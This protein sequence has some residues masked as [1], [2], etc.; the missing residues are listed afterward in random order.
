M[1][2]DRTADGRVNLQVDTTGLPP[3]VYVLQTVAADRSAVRVRRFTVA[4]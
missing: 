4:R 1:A 3:G 2:Y